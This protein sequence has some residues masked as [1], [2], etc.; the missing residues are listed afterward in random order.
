M[1]LILPLFLHSENH[2]LL[3]HLLIIKLFKFL[4]LMD[5]FQS[6]LHDLLLILGSVMQLHF[7]PDWYLLPL[8]PL[9]HNIPTIHYW[10]FKPICCKGS[11]W[12]IFLQCWT[13]TILTS[14]KRQSSYHGW[15]C[16]DGAGNTSPDLRFICKLNVGK[17]DG[18]VHTYTTDLG[19]VLWFKGSVEV[20]LFQIG[21]SLISS[22]CYERD[23]I[24]FGHLV[25]KFKIPFLASFFFIPLIIL[26]LHIC[27]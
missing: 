2:F 24:S 8:T 26:N 23:F 19:L 16:I 9:R 5:F 17:L 25:I 11:K 15:V 12:H 10:A 1:I 7:I 13:D 18:T 3:N 20:H 27:G 21:W 22:G 4:F 6:T 14:R